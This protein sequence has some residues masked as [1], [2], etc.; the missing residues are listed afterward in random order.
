MKEGLARE[1]LLVEGEDLAEKE[2]E[3]AVEE[4]AEGKAPEEE[5]VGEGKKGL[6]LAEQFEVVKVQEEVKSRHRSQVKQVNGLIYSL[7]RCFSKVLS[8]YPFLVCC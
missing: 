2:Q 5:V 6:I 3:V 4:E 1:Q 8:K 7:P